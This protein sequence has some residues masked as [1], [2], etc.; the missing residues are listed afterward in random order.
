MRHV[1]PERLPP[2]R[3]ASPLGS[4]SVPEQ[5]L[6]VLKICVLA[7]L[8]LFFLRVLRVVWQESRLVKDGAAN[9]APAGAAPIAAPVL[10]APSS[11]APAGEPSPMAP[12]PTVGSRPTRL[13]VIAPESLAGSVATLRDENT[14]GRAAT[15]ALPL[16]DTYV[17][18]L[19]ARIY[20]EGAH[21][22]VED[23]GSTNG[24]YLDSRRIVSPS[25]AHVGS[26]LEIG[27]IVMEFQ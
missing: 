3:A 20:Y 12:R 2:E 4:P 17:S 14:L 8:Y 5:L 10:P 7:L 18:Q 27:N 9:A 24:T 19:H 26:R 1:S 13:V 23:L 16:D 22:M 11:P 21:C 15:C 6:A 25:I